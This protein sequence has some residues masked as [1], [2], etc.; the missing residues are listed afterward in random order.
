MS[1]R[2]VP[3]GTAQSQQATPWPQPAGPLVPTAAPAVT[4]APYGS[5]APTLVPSPMPAAAFGGP[6]GLT[7]T[8]TPPR[9]RAPTQSPRSSSRPR[10]S[11]E[12]RGRNERS[13]SRERVRRE[14]DGDVPISQETVRDRINRVISCETTCRDNAA[15][16]ES[17]NTKILHLEVVT[18]KHESMLNHLNAK[19][20]DSTR[21][22]VELHNRLGQEDSDITTKANTYKLEMA[23]LNAR[24]Q[25]A[26]KAFNDL[27]ADVAVRMSHLQQMVQR[28]TENESVKTIPRPTGT[29][30]PSHFPYGGNTAPPQT[31]SPWSN[32]KAGWPEKMLIGISFSS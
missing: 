30:P 2:S 20:E 12:P 3:Y 16:V 23:R 11:S 18:T 8:P 5:G 32:Q 13:T 17:K 21:R 1:S 29:P 24:L 28:H 6:R 14:L 22:L 9:T 27:I 4:S 7:P 25:A 26:E 19:D 31:P 15:T 10:S